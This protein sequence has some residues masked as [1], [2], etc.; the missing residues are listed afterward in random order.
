LAERLA[1]LFNVA[2][3]ASGFDPTLVYVPVVVYGFGLEF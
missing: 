2:W 1:Q 3:A